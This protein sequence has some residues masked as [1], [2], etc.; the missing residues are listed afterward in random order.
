M[1][2][3]KFGTNG[4]LCEVTISDDGKKYHVNVTHPEHAELT[5]SKDVKTSDLDP[6]WPSVSRERHEELVA[7]VIE[8]LEDKRL[9]LKG[10]KLHSEIDDRLDRERK[11]RKLQ[12]EYAEAISEGKEAKDGSSAG[13]TPTV[14]DNTATDPSSDDADKADKQDDSN[15]DPA[16]S[17]DD[18]TTE[19]SK[20]T[21]EDTSK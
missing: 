3:S 7:P 10:D 14:E 21:S 2:T 16:T 12:L 17:A 15:V 1:A 9:S 5:A 18:K 11:E 13:G 19:D 6:Q 8:S 20:I 4:Y